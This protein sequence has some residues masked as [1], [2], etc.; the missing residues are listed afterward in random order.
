MANIFHRIKAILIPNLLT[1][2]PDD[3]YAKVISERTLNIEEI[4]EAAIAR[5]NAPTSVEAMKINVELFLKEMGYQ[6][7]DGY[8][9]NT[10][11]FIATPLIKGIFKH[12]KDR[13]DALRHSIQFLFTQGD[14]LRKG[15]SDVTVEITGVGEAGAVITEV[16]DVKTDS[17]NDRLTPNRNLRI[18]GS[19]LKLAGENPEVGVYFVNEATGEQT[20]VAADE[21]VNN[22]PSELVIIIPELAPGLYALKVITQFTGNTVLLKEPRT[23][24]F[25]KIL[26][27]V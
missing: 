2:D 1:E 5:G 16:T 4:C 22:K 7:K 25:D 15:L 3:F 26:N 19:K 17:T 12:A 21:V 8:S 11:Y 14:V 27:V 13:Y 20:K 10:G 24:S 23:I 6:L 9:V 18:K